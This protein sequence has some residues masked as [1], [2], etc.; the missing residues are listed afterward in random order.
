MS[1]KT[2]DVYRTAFLT[3]DGTLDTNNSQLYFR[4]LQNPKQPVSGHFY[5]L[6][7]AQSTDPTI[8]INQFSSNGTLLDY[9]F[10]YDT[11]FN[12]LPPGSRLFVAGGIGSAIMIYS[13]DGITWLA[14]NNGSTIFRG[15]TCNTIAWNGFTW[16]AGGSSGAASKLAYSSNGVFWNRSISGTSLLTN[17]CNTLIT[18]GSLWVAGGAG[19]NRVIYGYDGINWYPSITANNLQKT[20]CL[21]GA[22]NG[23]VWV[24]GG[25]IDTSGSQS[26][27]YSN[28][29]ISWFASNNGNTLFAT[30]KALAWNGS[31]WLA[32]GTPA[33]G[34]TNTLAYSYDGV[35]WKTV[36]T[37]TNL[38]TS[39]NAVAWSGAQWTAGGTDPSN[40]TL[41]YSNDGITWSRATN[42]SGFFTS[43]NSITWTGTLWIAG[44][45]GTDSFL[46]SY[47]G[48]NWNPIVAA[49]ALLTTCNTVV[50]NNVLPNAP[51]VQ[52]IN[53]VIPSTPLMLLGGAAV[54][55]EGSIIS[56]SADGITWSPNPSANLIFTGSTCR[57]LGW[58]GDQWIAGFSGGSAYLGNSYDGITWNANASASTLLTQ[59]CYSVG[60]NG[61]LW[62]AGGAG[63]SRLIYSIDGYTWSASSQG[64]A[65]FADASCLTIAYNGS[66]WVAGSNSS[67]NR[68]AFSTDGSN[69]WTASSTGNALFPS[70]CNSV[71]WNG[72]LWVAVGDTIAYSSDGNTWTRA[73]TIP[74]ATFWSS[75]AWNGLV[76]VVG[77][78]G[79]NPLIY[80]YDGNVWLASSNGSSIFDTGCTSVTWSGNLFLWVAAGNAI[81]RAAYSFNGITWITS[82]NSTSIMR[83]SNVVAINRLLVNAGITYP[84]PVLNPNPS[85]V[86]KAVYST[87]F[88]NLNV[89]SALTIS[90]TQGAIGINKSPSSYVDQTGKTVTPTIDIV[91]QG[92]WATTDTNGSFPGLYLTNTNSGDTENG[93]AGRILMQN[94]NRNLGWS[95]DSLWGA[96]SGVTIGTSLQIVQW[97]SGQSNVV[98]DFDTNG[99]VGVGCIPNNPP[100]TQPIFMDI[101]GTTRISSNLIVSR[102][103][104]AADLSANAVA[105]TGPIISSLPI[106]D[107]GISNSTINLASGT[108]TSRNWTAVYSLTNPARSYSTFLVN[109]NAVFDAS[110][111]S[112]LMTSILDISVNGITK[113]FLAGT[114]DTSG[115]PFTNKLYPISFTFIV[116][117]VINTITVSGNAS[118][119]IF[120]NTNGP[121]YLTTVDILGLT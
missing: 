12:T 71:T 14:S 1:Y 111:V 25:S 75:V 42:A 33:T 65:V 76:W 115:V 95:I 110:S 70:S 91:G 23:S 21:A 113:Y 11:Q 24:L 6:S 78:T 89:S 46:N 3:V 84:P 35:N 107:R 44:G 114:A 99:F 69:S 48:I 121:N 16:V 8:R 17:S 10:L 29:G 27:I 15:G 81:N 79:T 56:S 105:T 98:M 45:T 38:R 36:S 58:D 104:D 4:P 85:T 64:N 9:G 30:C 20:S 117:K 61:T 112:P 83:Q 5:S 108:N 62:L 116:N 94:T 40:N 73:A 86:G 97:I 120:V 103:I 32:G 55:G 119:G 109:V 100:Y 7:P 50:V 101:S 13:T 22:W 53:T 92:L 66:L 2:S 52:H 19:I 34:Q 96:N 88:N 87:G 68:L 31:I 106:S 60:T 67:N 57:A 80:S 26:L 102:H 54:L 28:D 41:I 18:N 51:I 49:E 77:G 59:G 37:T 63:I 72:L 74:S 43:C 93:Y 39:C 47:D 90:D 82:Y 118:S